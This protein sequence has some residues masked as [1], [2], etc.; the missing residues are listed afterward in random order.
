[1]RA[2]GA[3]W[4]KTGRQ[5]TIGGDGRDVAVGVGQSEDPKGDDQWKAPDCGYSFGLLKKQ[6][7]KKISVVLG[8]CG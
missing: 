5:E 8:Y 2:T 3:I 4:G 6:T 1:M 7:F